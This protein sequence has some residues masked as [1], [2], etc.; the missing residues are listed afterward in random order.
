MREGTFTVLRLQEL[1]VAQRRWLVEQRLGG[2]RAAEFENFVVPRLVLGRGVN[3]SISAGK[4][5]YFPEAHPF[6]SD[7]DAKGERSAAVRIL[8]KLFVAE[9]PTPQY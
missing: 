7:R 4:F 1:D 6:L 5:S 2:G 3:F 9:L 8:S